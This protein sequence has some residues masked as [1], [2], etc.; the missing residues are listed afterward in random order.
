M[1]ISCKNAYILSQQR[2]FNI[3][4]ACTAIEYSQSISIECS[5]VYCK[6]N[7]RCEFTSYINGNLVVYRNSSSCRS[8]NLCNR[9]GQ[10]SA[11]YAVAIDTIF[12]I[13]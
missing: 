2:S 4:I 9:A 5:N 8:F 13:R 1:L 7:S 3:S 10:F 11:F 6:C 12:R